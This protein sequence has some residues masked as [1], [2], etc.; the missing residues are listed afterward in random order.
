MTIFH[1]QK[2]QVN[3]RSYCF[4]LYM[5]TTNFTRSQ[6]ESDPIKN[7]TYT[8]LFFKISHRK[9]DFFDYN[10]SFTCISLMKRLGTLVS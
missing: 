10:L 7:P 5:I 9:R 1:I 8:M 2:R 3:D 6:P 4:L